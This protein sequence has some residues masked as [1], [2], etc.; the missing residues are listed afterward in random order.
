MI[1]MQRR[2]EGIVARLSSR[3]FVMIIDNYS[4]QHFVVLPCN[5]RIKS[6]LAQP[7]FGSH[8]KYYYIMKVLTI[9][10]PKRTNETRPHYSDIIRPH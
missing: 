10:M 7:S 1:I 3:H 2:E 9:K 6:F 8:K 4:K 5:Q